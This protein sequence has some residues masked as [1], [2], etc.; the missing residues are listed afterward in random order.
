MTD[1]SRR[2]FSRLIGAAGLGAGLLGSASVAHAAAGTTP[3]SGDAKDWLPIDHIVWAVPDL[4]RGVAQIAELTGLTPVSGGPGHGRDRPHNALLGLGNGAYLEVIAPGIGGSG[5]WL[6]QI[7]DNA[8][9][10]V[11]HARRITDRFARLKQV[12]KD[13]GYKHSDVRAM[14]RTTPDGNRLDWE[15]LNFA[16]TGFER[17]L[18][19]FIDWLKSDPHPADSAPQGVTIE[20]FSLA[21]PQ[22]DRVGKIYADLGIDMPVYASDKRGYNLVLNTPKGK[23]FLR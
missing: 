2:D 20:S 12:L 14:G 13:K 1:Y 9:R 18:P 16:G 19:F 15:L 21:H 23:V 22:A 17:D 5:P 11:S 3:K 4:E 7:N 10:I 8:P 6:E